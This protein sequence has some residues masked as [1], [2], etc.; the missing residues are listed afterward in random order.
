MSNEEQL[1][2]QIYQMQRQKY[3]DECT[4]AEKIGRLRGTVLELAKQVAQLTSSIQ[5]LK[6]HH[7]EANNGRPLIE[8]E[9]LTMCY[10]SEA[11]YTWSLKTSGQCT[12]TPG[13][14]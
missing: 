12:P 10:D 14:E 2:E 5:S 4:D 3:W 9:E 13:N 8:I 7:H 6:R 11:Y 1:K